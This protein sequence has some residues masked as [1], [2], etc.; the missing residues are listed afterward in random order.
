MVREKGLQ[1]AY[2]CMDIVRFSNT[3]MYPSFKLFSWIFLNI[4][5]SKRFSTTMLRYMKG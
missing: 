2:L 4:T 5:E 3:L 1:D